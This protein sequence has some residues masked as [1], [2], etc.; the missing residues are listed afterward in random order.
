VES[1]H[2]VKF[3]I[4]AESRKNAGSRIQ[5]GVK[6]TWTDKSGWFLFEVLR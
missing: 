3:R 6:T 1:F 2:I 4:E 5:A